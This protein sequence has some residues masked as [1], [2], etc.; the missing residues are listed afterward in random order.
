MIMLT[1]L[2]GR[3]CARMRGS[4]MTCFLRF[5]LIYL[6]LVIAGVYTVDKDLEHLY[7]AFLFVFYML[8]LSFGFYL[9]PFVFGL[10]Y[11][12]RF[13]LTFRQLLLY[14]GLLFLIGA[15]AFSFWFPPLPF[16]PRYDPSHWRSI[17]LLAFRQALC[18]LGGALLTAGG[19]YLQMR[20]GSRKEDL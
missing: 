16:L 19:K 15:A 5:F 6:G 14:S 20:G 3:M 2:S 13:S 18:F 11:Q 4:P 9:I 12:Y 17:R 8:M 10:A 1:Y 7:D